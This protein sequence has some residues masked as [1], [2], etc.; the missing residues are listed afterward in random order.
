M[1]TAVV[2]LLALLALAMVAAHAGHDHHDH[3]HD[4]DDPDHD[5]AHDHAH[6]HA[7]GHSHSQAKDVSYT[8][9]KFPGKAVFVETFDPTWTQRWTFLE[10]AKYNGPWRVEQPTEFQGLPGDKG[11]VA[12]EKARH[13][14]AAAAFSKPWDPKGKE[15]VLQYEVRLQQGQECGGAYVKLV[16][17][18]DGKAFNPKKFKNDTPYVIMFGPDKC[19]ATNVVHFIFRHKNPKTGEWEE[20]HLQNGPIPVNDKMTHLYTLHV[21]PDNTFEIF[22]DQ[23]SHSKG[24]LLDNFKPPVNP[25]AEID[26]PTDKKPADWVDITEIP[27]PEAKKPADWD[28]SQPKSIADPEDTKPA[29]WDENAPAQI[30]DPEAVKPADWSVED[31]GEWVPRLVPNPKCEDVGCGP[32]TPRQI[33]NPKYKGLWTAPKIPNPAYKGPWKARQIPNPNYFKDDHPANFSPIVV[34]ASTFGP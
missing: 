29:D 21:K 11:L 10:D 26:D 6:G 14:G 3:D 28:E 16:S 25:P 9:P 30:P 8:P 18:E 20:K 5:H 2:L 19:G 1:K 31:D 12:T 33:P 13:Y 4:H 23:V 27:D 32:W 15:L 7:H 34:S 24:T 22:I 17:A